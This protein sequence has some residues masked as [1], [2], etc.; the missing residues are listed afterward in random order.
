MK[1]YMKPEVELKDMLIESIM[2]ITSDPLDDDD[3][4]G[5]DQPHAKEGIWEYL[6]EE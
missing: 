5:D 6:E 2:Q 1:E 4:W 3:D